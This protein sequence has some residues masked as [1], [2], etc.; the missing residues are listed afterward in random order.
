MG[1]LELDNKERAH[2]NVLVGMDGFPVLQ[3]IFENELEKFHIKLLNTDPADEHS[4]LAAHRMEKAAAQY[5]QG[6]MKQLQMEIEA[7]RQLPKATD[8]P[9]DMT[10]GLFDDVADAVADLPNLLGGDDI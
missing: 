8:K 3:K 10:E 5:Y 1:E 6:C 7:Y 9:I 2:L 4:V